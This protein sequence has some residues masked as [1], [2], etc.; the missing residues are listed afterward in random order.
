MQFYTISEDYAEYLR[1][2]DASIPNIKGNGYKNPKPFIGIVLHIDDHRYVAPLTSPKEWHDSIKN[3]SPMYFKI[4]ENG[5]PDH[6]LGLVNLKFMFPILDDYSSLIDLENHDDEKY[7]QLLYKQLEFI[8]PNS[9]KLGKKAALL[10]KLFF[11]G[12]VKGTCNF[13]SLEECYKKFRP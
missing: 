10:R 4:H 13:A 7:Q 6:K 11:E 2:I 3:S 8:R 1:G 5:N 12:K 9:E